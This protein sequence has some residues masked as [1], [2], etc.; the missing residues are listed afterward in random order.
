MGDRGGSS[1]TLMD[2]MDAVGV[3]EEDTTVARKRELREKI[4]VAF[5]QFGI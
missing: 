1:S 2:G 3:P 4:Q 5:L